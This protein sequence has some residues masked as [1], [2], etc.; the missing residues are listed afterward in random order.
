MSQKPPTDYRRT[1][2]SILR[3]I[4]IGFAV[5][6][7]LVGAIFIP[8]SYGWLGLAGGMACIFVSIIPIGAT[9]LAVVGIDKLSKWLEEKDEG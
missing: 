9:V 3:N 8:Y 4:V 2:Y 7:L 1:N 6:I 5:V